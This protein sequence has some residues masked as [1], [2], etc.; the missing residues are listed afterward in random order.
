MK[1][2]IYT[3]LALILS[4]LSL[5]AQTVQ[6]Y[7]E[8]QKC[9]DQIKQIDTFDIDACNNL[10]P[11]FTE[12][13]FLQS[14]GDYKA[15]NFKLLQQYVKLTA[16]T[17]PINIEIFRNLGLN[18]YFTEKYD[19]S[20]IFFKKAISFEKKLDTIVLSPTLYVNIASI[21]RIKNEL[22]SA[23]LYNHKAQYS[24]QEKNDSL[25]LAKVQN[26]LGNLFRNKNP[27]KSIHHYLN[28]ASIYNSFND[29]INTAKVN[30]NLGLMFSDMKEKDLALS[31]FFKALEVFKNSKDTYF[32]IKILNNIS[33]I[34]I[35]KAEYYLAEEYL[36]ESLNINQDLERSKMYTLFNLGHL[37]HLTK[38]HKISKKYYIEALSLARKFE[39]LDLQRRIYNNL[40]YLSIES[41]DMMSFEDYFVL[42]KD[43]A[44]KISEIDYKEQLARY[45]QTLEVEKTKNLL[46]TTERDAQLKREELARKEAE[47]NTKNVL[48][49]LGIISMI[50]LITLIITIYGIS[51]KRKALT[52]SIRHQKNIIAN[53]NRQLE[54]TVRERTKEL[55]IAKIKAEESDLLKSTFLA[56]IS[57]EI[58]T[59]LNSIMGFSDILCEEDRSIEDIKGYSNIIRSNGFILLNIIGDL[60]DVSKIEA[61]MFDIKTQ[62]VSHLNIISLIEEENYDKPKFFEKVGIIDFTTDF[63]GEDFKLKTDL[64]KLALVFE[65]LINNAFQFTEEGFVEIGSKRIKDE[66]EFYV[67]D[68][69]VGIPKGR[70][71]EIFENFRKFR[72]DQHLKYSGLGVGLFIAKYIIE[73]MGSKLIVDSK[74]NKGSTF[75]FKLPIDNE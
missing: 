29:S 28:A 54:D 48:L 42:Y 15:S 72:S 47:L 68:S 1:R 60:I 34:Y 17:S 23:I 2:N 36:F 26:N 66:I 64:H 39:D 9:K 40:I 35:D 8:I 24:F 44:I 50:L 55:E 41:K 10:Y 49:V 73:E 27:E 62:T 16:T 67:S 61:N 18:Y 7:E 14:K 43:I 31:Y 38:K 69:G 3:T 71:E 52:Q 12:A 22:D 11:K 75:S 33:L 32:Q 30:N 6:E 57:H 65:K 37:K 19:S 5:K 70:L 58:R 63:Y 59:P 46:L 4:L 53:H 56:N 25:G 20:I 51:Q 45:E 21:Y 13:I 74:V